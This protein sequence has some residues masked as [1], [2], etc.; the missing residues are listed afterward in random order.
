MDSSDKELEEQLLEAGNKLVDPPSSV[1][2]LLRVLDRLE[3]CLILVEQSP[4]KS[5]QN[6]L[7]PSLKAL[8][9]DKLLKHTH[10]DVKVAVASCISEITRITA[11]DAPYDDDQMR[12]VFRLIVSSFE[13]L[14]DKSSRSYT[15]RTAILET[16]AK[17]RSCV[18]MLDLE[19]DDLILEM[20]Q[21]FLTTIR[22]HHPEAVFSSME[23]VMILVLE[24][25]ED[26]SLDLLSPILESIKKD[27]EEVSPIARKLVEKVLERCA[28]RLKPYIKQAVD[29]LGISLDDYSNVLASICQDTSGSLE[30]NDACAT[31]D[32]AEDES[33]SG[34]EPVK[35]SEQVV[36]ENSKEDAPP[37]EDNPEG[38]RSPKSVMSNGIAQTGED[39]T[40]VDPKSLKKQG[41]TDGAV[42]SEGINLS[43]NGESNDLDGEKIENSES[44]AEQSTKGRGRKPSASKLVEPSE[45]SYLANE[46]ET[47]KVIESHSKDVPSST[48]EDDC[49]EATRPS[50]NDKEIDA[51][52]SSPKAGDG[53][54]DAVA[55][56]SPSESIHDENHSKKRGRS[57]KKAS[58][59]KEGVA[60]NV[61]KKVSEGTSD[62][63]GKPLKPS[64]KKGQGRTSDVKKT[65][66]VDAVKKGSGATSDVDGKKQS[67]KK[68][69]DRNKGGGGSSSRQLEDKRKKGRGKGN[70]E[71]GLAK[72]STKDDDKEMVSSPK[73][74]VKSTKDEHSEETPKTNL[75]RKRTP[76]KEN[77]SNS[78][79]YGQELVGSR[80]KVWWPDDQ[81]F[82]E[83]VVDYFDS[84][85]KRHK[86]SY[87]DGDEEV[88]LLKREKWKI[89]DDGSDSDGGD[90]SDRTSPD[91]SA[92]LLPKKK[93]KTSG[94]ELKKG[95]K[96]DS[97]KS[98]GASSSKS[99][100]GTSA[101]SSNRSKDGSKADRKSKDSKTAV[102]SEDEVSRKS[103]DHSLKS[104]GSKSIDASQKGKS[105]NTDSSKIIRSKDDDVSTSKTSAKSKQET[106]KTG[107]SKQEASKPASSSKA[108]STKSGT[109]SNTNGT[110]KV[111]SNL[112]KTKDSENEHSENSTKVVEDTKGK[113]SS[114][115]KAGSEAKSGKKRGRN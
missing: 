78:K 100:G 18:V 2:D 23:T 61:S 5:M 107:K 112:L 93:G 63:E 82:Y 72:S 56:P 69:E 86:V 110:G 10:V 74:A 99:K 84:A 67:A 48:H 95:G 26:I 33:K 89:I 38:D 115:L 71:K 60:E 27:N 94:S 13:N 44:K 57:K 21:H 4:S 35:E 81:M 11:P 51:K 15:K 17:V 22:D 76:G 85:T 97:S 80:V 37:P 103:K 28:T 87:D 66:M 46:K 45:G 49:A 77:E 55:S 101:K 68:A 105:K 83:G 40:S 58:S 31:S 9:A 16:V 20:F 73:S 34:K 41:D 29:H 25:S 114:S 52:I 54:S 98:G 6:A 96:K 108:K 104:G 91:A 64:V 36:R 92:D 19:C 42:H 24:E 106:P 53:E 30:Q 111:K 75:K 62:S 88:L 47:E 8:I 39:D 90:G 70:P 12:D 113:T 79:K 14:H 7:S 65:T 3:C 43:G 50:E 1:D 59:A 32:H 109:K 102:K